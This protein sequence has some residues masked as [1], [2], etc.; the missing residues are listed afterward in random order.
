MSTKLD[1]E[2]NLV[3]FSFINKLGN[4]IENSYYRLL[5]TFEN[6]FEQ[7]HYFRY[8]EKYLKKGRSEKLRGSRVTDACRFT[9]LIY[10]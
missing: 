3:L 8:V 1:V 2:T 5:F 7:F 4:F 6:N 9:L 10:E